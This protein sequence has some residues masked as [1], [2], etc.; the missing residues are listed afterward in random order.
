MNGNLKKVYVIKD[1]WDNT[2]RTDKKEVWHENLVF[3]KHYITCE[4]AE[5]DVIP[6]ST[7]ITLY[8]N[9]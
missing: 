5:R 8:V 4:E 1:L 9:D 6:H 3:A 7:I 2:Y